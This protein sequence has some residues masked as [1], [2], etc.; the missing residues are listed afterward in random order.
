MRRPTVPSLR[1]ILALLAGSVGATVAAPAEAAIVT[2]RVNTLADSDLSTHCMGGTS[3]CTLRAAFRIA[4]QRPTDDFDV[5]LDVATTDSAPYA[6]NSSAL[7]LR[8]GRVEVFTPTGLPSKGI[9]DARSQSWRVIEVTGDT[10]F[11]PSL[12]LR[13]V[14]IRNGRVGDEEGGGGIR[15]GARAF[16]GLADS[17]VEGN[18]AGI[19]AGIAVET[20]ASVNIINTIVRNNKIR[21][22]EQGTCGTGFFTV[23]GGLSLNGRAMILS[24]TFEN[25]AACRGAGIM[26][27]GGNL[28]ME[29]STLRG[30]RADIVGGALFVTGGT[31]SNAITLRFNTISL[32]EAA[33]VHPSNQFA[34]GGGIA[35]RSFPGSLILSG[36]VIAQNKLVTV[37][38]RIAGPEG[39]KTGG[40]DCLIEGA[41]PLFD[42][43][44][45]FFGTVGSTNSTNV[46]ASIP[47]AGTM[48]RLSD[49]VPFRK[50]SNAGRDGVQ[51]NALLTY[52]DTSFANPFQSSYFTSTSAIITGDGF[53]KSSTSS[54]NHRCLSGDQRG[55][56]RPTA[57]SNVC[58][59]GSIETGATF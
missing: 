54:G 53:R 16:V 58:D 4:D 44:G 38:T 36:N 42:T 2:L 17:V 37:D 47:I 21:A 31:S 18:V 40:I 14:T 56:T 30:N 41:T 7:T 6:V 12:D 3:T 24:S 46:V 28:T 39:V 13:G 33:R 9:I 55:R 51:L 52:Q 1:T 45:N 23:A 57:S 29:N 8:R 35:I 32:N 26:V 15:V 27:S 50:D 11:F 25:N 19:G 48:V 22:S 5:I 43:F 59:M 10:G 49:C 20:S 34:Y